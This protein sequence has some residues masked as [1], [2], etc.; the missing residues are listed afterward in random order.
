MTQ[1]TK[2]PNGA[3]GLAL[4]T[5]L[6]MGTLVLGSDLLSVSQAHAE[7]RR[8]CAMNPVQQ[9]ICIYQTILADVARTYAQRGGGGISSIVQNT[10]TTFTV[11]IAQERRKDLLNYTVRIG[12]DG[13]VTILGKTE[14]TQSY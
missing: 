3:R 9:S 7:K 10:T 8:T 11:H 14:S 13:G 2:L 6:M 5:S 12:P 4:C 1:R